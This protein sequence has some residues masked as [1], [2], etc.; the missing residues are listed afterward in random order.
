[1]ELKINK[2]SEFK[3]T[4]TPLLQPKNKVTEA[5]WVMLSSNFSSIPVTDEKGILKGVISINDVIKYFP[6]SIDVISKEG[7]IRSHEIVNKISLP[8]KRVKDLMSNSAVSITLE[9]SL[10]EILPLFTEK[11]VFGKVGHRSTYFTGF[12]VIDNNGQVF[13]MI[14]Y[15]DILKLINTN[16]NLPQISQF[17]YK[18]DFVYLEGADNLMKANLIMQS[19]GIRN[20]IVVE[21]DKDNLK[22]IGII[23]DTQLKRYMQEI[24]DFSKTQVSDIMTDITSIQTVTETEPINKLINIFCNKNIGVRIYPV[25]NKRG[26][27]VGIVSY[28]DILRKIV[29]N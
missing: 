25:T 23:A 29:I 5:I 20:I 7:G 1:M 28:V 11:Q 16:K 9:T 2:L 17:I 27:M 22:P 19:L 8:L 18:G 24:Y 12:P 14:T 4:P 6:P 10:K 13:G 21:K 15:I 3:F 26:Y